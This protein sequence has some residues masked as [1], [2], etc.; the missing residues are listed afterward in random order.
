MSVN[1]KGQ[2]HQTRII[3]TTACQ[4][5]SA[6]TPIRAKGRTPRFCSPTCRNAEFRARRRVATLE[7]EL[8]AAR[9]ALLTGGTHADQMTIAEALGSEI[10]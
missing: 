8:Q 5:C 6:M 4:W 1:E 3:E 7:K 9:M 10:D 2:P